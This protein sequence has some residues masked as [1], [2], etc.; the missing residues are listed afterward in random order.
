MSLYKNKTN[1]PT[2]QT[3]TRKFK[4][5]TWDICKRFSKDRDEEI[6]S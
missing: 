5:G 2:N 4:T 1:Q 6:E 3:N